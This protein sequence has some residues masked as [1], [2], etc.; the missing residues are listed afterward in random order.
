M[1]ETAII[2]N[3]SGNDRYAQ[4]S[5]DLLANPVRANL[6]KII[7]DNESQLNNLIQIRNQTSFGGESN[8]D[9]SLKNYV[10]AL[11]KTNLILEIPLNP[12]INLDG[13]TYFQT[14]LA[15][16]ST[17]DMIFFEDKNE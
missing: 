3:N 14:E 5:R 6:L 9:I 13:E 12:A 2:L 8:R 11:N 15:A 17:I 16:N 1:A 4:V 10:N 7:L